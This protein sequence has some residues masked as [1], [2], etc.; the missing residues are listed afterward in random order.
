MVMRSLTSA[1][2]LLRTNSSA[3]P[4]SASLR[5]TSCTLTSGMLLLM[6]SSSVLSVRKR[7]RAS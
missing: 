5:L 3:E 4:V 6:L 7:K 1:L 2:T